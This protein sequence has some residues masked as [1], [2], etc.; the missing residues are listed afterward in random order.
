M[1]LFC[2]SC[3]R[4]VHPTYWG[5]KAIGDQI[6]P[7]VCQT[8]PTGAHTVPDEVCGFDTDGDNN[9]AM[10]LCRHC[11]PE[12]FPSVK[13]PHEAFVR[14]Q[15]KQMNHLRGLLDPKTVLIDHRSSGY[16]GTHDTAV[17]INALDRAASLA[18]AI[19]GVADSKEAR[20]VLD[21]CENAL[22][23]LRTRMQESHV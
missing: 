11:R 15:N 18:R 6:D 7:L 21:Q 12:N 20:L 22:A 14:W 16:S 10:A 1:V 13:Q 3:Q 19:L 8:S 4:T 9:C 2:T 5:P 23:L 17:L